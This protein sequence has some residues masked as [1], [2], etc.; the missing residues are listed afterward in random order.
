MENVADRV[1]KEMKK[2]SLLK[3]V[4]QTIR[5]Q[6]LPTAAAFVDRFNATRHAVVALKCLLFVHHIA[7]RG[8][9]ILQEQLSVYPS[10]CIR[11]HLSLSNFQR[12]RNTSN[13]TSKQLSLRPPQ[14]RSDSGLYWM[15]RYEY[16]IAPM[17]VFVYEV[18]CFSR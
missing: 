5:S 10:S 4:G 13:P 18:R 8:T 2:K 15:R 9:F 14:I 16:H 11:N 1:S 3:S 17:F 6:G 12:R 7:H